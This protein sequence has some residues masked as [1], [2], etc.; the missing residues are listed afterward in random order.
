M[1]ID[2][3]RGARNIINFCFLFFV[4]FLDLFVPMAFTHGV[5]K[6]IKEEE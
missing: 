2:Q 1:Y 5:E 6:V 4:L 3:Y